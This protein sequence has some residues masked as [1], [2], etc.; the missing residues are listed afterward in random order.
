[1]PS[2]NKFTSDYIEITLS[3]VA[4][5]N[6]KTIVDFNKETMSKLVGR[7]IFTRKSINL[8]KQYA[9]IKLNGKAVLLHRYIMGAI[10]NKE[11]DVDHINGN[12]L[13]NRSIN[14]RVCTGVENAKN[15]LR[16]VSN[17]SG[18]KGVSR[19]IKRWE[20]KHGKMEKITYTPKIQSDF[21]RINLGYYSTPEEAAYIY[22]QFALQLHGEYAN[23]NFIYDG[24]NDYLIDNPL[25]NPKNKH[26]N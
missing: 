5:H 10:D 25:H 14:L 20:N 7:S 19:Y 15:R 8:N 11:M 26:L 12:S 17:K 16:S 13:D 3:G 9:F 23:T 2:S 21:T 6:L 4:G 22:D 24:I 1:M 18:Y